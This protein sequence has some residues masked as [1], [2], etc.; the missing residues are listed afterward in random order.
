MGAGIHDEEGKLVAGLSLSAPSDR[1]DKAWAAEVKQT[2]DQ[3]SYAIGFRP[4][5]RAA[6]VRSQAGQSVE[7]A[8]NSL[9]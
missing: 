7:A 5:R 1:L 9:R 6:D 4:A 3:I 8:A 2:A